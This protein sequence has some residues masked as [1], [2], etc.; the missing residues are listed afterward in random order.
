MAEEVVSGDPQGMDHPNHSDEEIYRL[1]EDDERELQSV[2]AQLN[3]LR[4]RI[5]TLVPTDSHLEGLRETFPFGT[6]GNRRSG[7]TQFQKRFD[8]SI[9][10]A[11]KAAPLIRSSF[12]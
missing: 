5:D 1:T 3:Q 9:E 4:Q 6:G 11:G 10:R 7:G 12:A 8:L 2:R